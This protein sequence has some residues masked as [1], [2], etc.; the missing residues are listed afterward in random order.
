MCQAYLG[1][2]SSTRSCPVAV[3]W[4]TLLPQDTP[5]NLDDELVESSMCRNTHADVCA[6]TPLFSFVFNSIFDC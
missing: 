3:L 6:Q 2:E 5:D 4:P 1:L